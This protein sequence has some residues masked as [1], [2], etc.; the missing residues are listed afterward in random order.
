MGEVEG[1]KI[2]IIIIIIIKQ[3]ALTKT[4]KTHTAAP[5]WRSLSSFDAVAELSTGY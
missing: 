4:P 1:G 5:F 2:I 3:T